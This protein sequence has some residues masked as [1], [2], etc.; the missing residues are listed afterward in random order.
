M[1]CYCFLRPMG[2]HHT[3]RSYIT[4]SLRRLSFRKRVAFQ[5]EVCTSQCSN[6]CKL[7]LSLIFQWI[8]SRDESH[9]GK[10]RLRQKT[11]LP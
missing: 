1:T 8:I 2:K 7:V 4:G 10:I 5:N 3:S 11:K 6:P 9:R